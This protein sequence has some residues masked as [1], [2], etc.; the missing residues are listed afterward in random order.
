MPTRCFCCII[1]IC[2]YILQTLNLTSQPDNSI[3]IHVTDNCPCLQ[4]DNGSTTVTGVN[5]PCCGNVNHFDLSYFGFERL[6]HP[7]YGL[8]NLQFRSVSCATAV[9]APLLLLLL[10]H[11]CSLPCMS[12]VA[13]APEAQ[14]ARALLWPLILQA[15]AHRSRQHA[16]CW[17]NLRLHSERQASAVLAMPKLNCLSAAP[18]FNAASSAPLHASSELIPCAA[19]LLTVTAKYPW[20]TCQAMS[21]RPSMVTT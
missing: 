2:V 1:D 8:M 12:G 6:A 21:T 18:P 15:H 13:A 19:G 16:A 9:A 7:N 4:Y 17:R 5:A 10:Q 14:H 20:S 3:Y 11:L